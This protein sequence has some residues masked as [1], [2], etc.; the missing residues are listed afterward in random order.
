MDMASM[1]AVAC[2]PRVVTWN[3]TKPKKE[4]INK[5]GL[6]F[7]SSC[8]LSFLFFGVLEHST[9]MVVLYLVQ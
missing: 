8:S 7:S 3:A 5:K 6:P 2:E 9:V 4:I 1:R